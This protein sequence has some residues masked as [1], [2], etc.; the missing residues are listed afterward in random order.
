MVTEEVRR[1]GVGE[2]VARAGL[3]QLRN[4]ET[5]KYAHVTFFFNGGEERVFDGEERILVPSPKVQ[6]YDLKPEMSAPEVTDKLVE[7]IGSGKF[8]LIVVN[9]SN[10][11]LVA[12]SRDLPAALTPVQ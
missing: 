8:D 7:A 9:Y 11:A 10:T 2:T 5:E 3:K 12:H 6:T 4:A 1:M